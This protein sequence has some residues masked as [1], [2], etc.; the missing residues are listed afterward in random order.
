M[1]LSSLFYFKEPLLN[2]LQYCF[3]FEVLFFRTRG[4]WDF[5]SLSTPCTGRWGLNHWTSRDI[6]VYLCFKKHLFGFGRSSLQHVG[7]SV[8][9]AARRTRA[10]ALGA[11]SLSRWTSREALLSIFITTVRVC[12]KTAPWVCCVLRSAFPPVS[13][14]SYLGFVSLPRV[15][16]LASL[17]Q[18]TLSE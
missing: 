11:R 12:V 3:C 2:L 7:S 1:C 18:Q 8:F 16:P 15:P 14:I 9:P 4:L 6:P 10:R 13:L 5:S 17:L